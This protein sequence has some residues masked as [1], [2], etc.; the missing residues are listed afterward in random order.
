[1][2][3]QEGETFFEESREIVSKACSVYGLIQDLKDLIEYGMSEKV[4]EKEIELE[5]Y[6]ESLEDEEEDE[7][8][9]DSSEERDY[10]CVRV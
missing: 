7:D 10:V 5:E 3:D 9:D 2:H 8:E 4:D 6:K 1:M